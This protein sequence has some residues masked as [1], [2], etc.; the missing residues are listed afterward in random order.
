VNRLTSK[1]AVVPILQRVP[2]PDD[3]QL[4]LE[5]RLCLSPLSKNLDGELGRPE[6][7]RR[8]C[9]DDPRCLTL[10]TRQTLKLGVTGNPPC[11]DDPA[12]LTGAI[13]VTDLV[14]VFDG[15]AGRRGFHSGE[16]R[17]QSGRTLIFGRLS[18]IT[19]AGTHRP[20]TLPCQECHALGFLQG[21]LCGRI[22]RAE[23]DR[24]RG[25]QVFANY[26][27]HAPEVQ[28]DGIVAQRVRGALEGLLV[29]GCGCCG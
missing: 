12:G 17:W 1:E 29:C 4:L 7:E 24:V 6:P 20:E 19:H 11:D 9:D 15:D 5:Q 14:H 22:V 3:P 10:T 16:F 27:L 18:G 23:D 28:G 2:C 21:R 25:C 8:Q 26:L 13:V